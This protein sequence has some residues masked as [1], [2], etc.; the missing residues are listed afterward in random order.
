[1]TKYP[2][3]PNPRGGKPFARIFFPW[4]VSVQRIEGRDGR[5]IGPVPAATIKCNCICSRIHMTPSTSPKPS[6]PGR[7]RLV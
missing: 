7:V 1:M 6:E 4:A 3:S 5:G 2:G